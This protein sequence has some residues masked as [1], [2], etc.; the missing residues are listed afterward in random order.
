MPKVP[1]A[2]VIL[3]TDYNAIRSVFGKGASKS[4][5]EAV[6]ENNVFHFSNTNKDNLIKFKATFG[7]GSKHFFTIDLIDPTNEFESNFLKINLPQK[8]VNSFFSF[9]GE[10]LPENTPLVKKLEAKDSLTK[11]Q[12]RT[13][14]KIISQIRR[15]D[16][17]DQMLGKIHIEDPRRK[18]IEAELDKARD[19]LPHP[20]I[21]GVVGY[22]QNMDTGRISLDYYNDNRRGVL[23]PHPSYKDTIEAFQRTLQADKDYRNS[24]LEKNKDIDRRNQEILKQNQENREFNLIP[25][26]EMVQKAINRFLR[27]GV[28]S[29]RFFIAFGLGDDTS[30]WGGPY[31]VELVGANLNVTADNLRKITLHFAPLTGLL[32]L[33]VDITQ[34]P[35]RLDLQGFGIKAE[36]KSE[37]IDVTHQALRD[38]KGQIRRIY[39]DIDLQAERLTDDGKQT[40]QRKVGE[41]VDKLI[42]D[43]NIHKIITQCIRHYLMSVCQTENVVVLLPNINEINWRTYVSKFQSI[44]ASHVKEKDKIPVSLFG[45]NLFNIPLPTDAESAALQRSFD[46]FRTRKTITP[47]VPNSLIDVYSKYDSIIEQFLKSILEEYGLRVDKQRVDDKAVIVGPTYRKRVEQ[48]TIANHPFICNL[49]SD[50]R[51]KTENFW[52]KDK[53]EFIGNIPNFKDPIDKVIKHLEKGSSMHDL[54]T[55]FWE[56]DIGL[57]EVWQK[58]LPEM[59]KDNSKPVVIFGSSDLIQVYLYGKHQHLLDQPAAA[60][61]FFKSAPFL[62]PEDDRSNFSNQLHPDDYKAFGQKPMHKDIAKVVKGEDNKFLKSPLADFFNIPEETFSPDELSL[63][64]EKV[65]KYAFP[66][67]RSMTKNPNVLR[68]DIDYDDTYMN[69]LKFGFERVFQFYPTLSESDRKKIEENYSLKS[70]WYDI[71]TKFRLN[72]IDAPE[73]TKALRE[74]LNLDISKDSLIAEFLAL[75]YDL[76]STDPTRPKLTINE[77]D[78]TDPIRLQAQLFANLMPRMATA[79]VKTLPF[80]RASSHYF[81]KQLCLLVAKQPP[82]IG[83]DF[84][85]GEENSFYSGPYHILEWE[86]NISNSDVSSTFKLVKQLSSVTNSELNQENRTTKSERKAPDEL[87]LPK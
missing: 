73:A 37:P 33:G 49:T 39:N 34:T 61:P 31:S 6:A 45:F 75:V 26:E 11:S 68:L 65:K 42:K 2:G 12:T 25:K 7:Q 56:S 8:L 18:I 20:G 66:V 76:N 70:D 60:R 10:S 63:V 62:I 72:H 28:A 41:S 64:Q 17:I 32:P 1:A 77:E 53:R 80:F 27:N 23:L 13:V 52:D 85:V 3:T 81:I 43:V 4:L 84:K 46:P 69:F 24:I 5:T 87:G 67:F 15:I 78:G 79:E 30:Q 50:W 47:G 35:L 38:V 22:T 14:Q 59:I 16:Q 48:G 55:M 19:K 86:H 58:Y 82:I 44:V 51:D 9:T 54:G 83:S 21:L 29:N 36:G 71:I 74:A 40:F 57:T